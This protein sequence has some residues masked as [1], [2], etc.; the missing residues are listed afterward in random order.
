VK[1]DSEEAAGPIQ[2]R[3]KFRADIVIMIVSALFRFD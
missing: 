3:F 2:E 1:D